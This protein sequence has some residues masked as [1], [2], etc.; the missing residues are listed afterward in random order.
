ME[1]SAQP[2]IRVKDL[3]LSYEEHLVMR[4]LN[5]SVNKGEIF[6]V[7]GQSGCGKSTLLKALIGLKE[8]AKGEIFYNGVSFWPQDE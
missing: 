8:P 2:V 1:E 5:F 3:E 6:V 4:D 7:M